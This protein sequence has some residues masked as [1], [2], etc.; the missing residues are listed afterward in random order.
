MLL[1]RMFETR[2]SCSYAELSNGALTADCDCEAATLIAGV[3]CALGKEHCNGVKVTSLITSFRDTCSAR[4]EG[5][6]PET[7]GLKAGVGFLGGGSKPPLHQLGSLGSA[8]PA[9][10]GAE[11]QPPNDFPRI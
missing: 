1:D 4:P 11:P 5:P 8:P 6:Q 2:L 7:G 10:S 3:M 9:G